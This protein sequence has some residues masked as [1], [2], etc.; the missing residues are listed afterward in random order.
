MLREL[1]ANIQGSSPQAYVGVCLVLVYFVILALV[2]VKR[3]K[4]GEIS[5][6]REKPVRNRPEGG[7]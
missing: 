6:R 1:L 4:D 5:R 2:A 7:L 3:I